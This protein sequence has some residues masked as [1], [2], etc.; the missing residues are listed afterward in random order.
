[1]NL[2]KCLIWFG[3]VVVV[4]F[5]LDVLFGKMFKAYMDRYRLAGDYE[6]V[7]HLLKSADEDIVV[8]GSSVALNGINTKTLEDSLGVTAYNGGANGQ[9]FPYYLT[10]LKA[11]LEQKP[12]RKIVLGMIPSNLSDTGIGGRYNFLAPYYG[13][14]IGD[15]DSRLHGGDELERVFLQSNF[16]RLNRIW[17]RILLYNFVT[18]GIQGEN[19]FIAKPVPPEYPE[20]LKWEEDEEMSEER[21]AEFEEFVNLCRDNG[22]ELTVVFA[23]RCVDRGIGTH[24]VADRVRELS[25][26][27]GFRFYDDTF[28]P[29][30]DEVDSLFYDD[31]HVN[32]NGSAIYTDSIINRLR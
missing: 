7:D 27:Y 28:L 11:V 23:P 6:M 10:I 13:A 16:Y 1:M 21:R 4:I 19:G 15:I 8:L 14:G 26:K 5:I 25:E 17:F 29:P 32:I 20:R 18:A 24:K 31:R 30:F 9:M 12:P 2:K 3:I 22:V